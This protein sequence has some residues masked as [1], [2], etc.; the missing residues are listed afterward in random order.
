MSQAVQEMQ[1]LGERL[2]YLGQTDQLDPKD[3]GANLGRQEN[4]GQQEKEANL[5]HQEIQASVEETVM[6]LHSLYA[7]LHNQSIV[8]S[9]YYLL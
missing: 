6:Y 3:R 2:V 8:F 1:D 9:F 5:G 7:T 4:Q